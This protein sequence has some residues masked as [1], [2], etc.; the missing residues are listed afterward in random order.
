MTAFVNDDAND[1]DDDVYRP[2][3]VKSEEDSDVTSANSQEIA[4]EM[5]NSPPAVE[6]QRPLTW[7]KRRMHCRDEIRRTVLSRLLRA[8]RLQKQRE[9]RTLQAPPR[10]RC[11]KRVAAVADLR[12]SIAD[13]IYVDEWPLPVT[14]IVC[15]YLRD[16]SSLF[17]AHGAASPQPHPRHS[18]SCPRHSQTFP[19]AIPT[20]KNNETRRR[21]PSKEVTWVD[22][23]MATVKRSAL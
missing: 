21:L 18:H 1:D 10:A 15:G 2:L 14:P 13:E 6:K 8:A 3:G 11:K 9:P 19:C 16:S 20:H 7:E 12:F 5:P 17:E 4:V 22:R 23:S